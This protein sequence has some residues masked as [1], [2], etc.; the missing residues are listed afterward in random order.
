M[1]IGVYAKDGSLRLITA[2]RGEAMDV[3]HSEPC[4]GILLRRNKYALPLRIGGGNA[5]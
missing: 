5:Y 2:D 3:I 1:V 4:R